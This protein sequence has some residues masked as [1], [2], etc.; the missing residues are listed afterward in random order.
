MTDPDLE[1]VVVIAPHHDDEVIGCGGTIVDLAGRGHPVDV[2][3]VTA[4]YCAQPGISDREVATAISE[5]EARKAGRL[6]GVRQQIFLREPDRAISYS[7]D[8]L[9]AMIRI[10]RKG[11]YAGVYFPHQDETD[12]E[13]RV[14][15]EVMNEAVWLAATAYLPELGEP[16]RLSRVQTYE[17]W[18]PFSSFHVQ[19]D[20]SPYIELKIE[21]LSAY[22]SK[23]SRTMAEQIVGLNHYRGAMAGR[24]ARAMEVFRIHAR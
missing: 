19:N 5:A 1:S 21:A 9:Y 17:V 16:V 11:V 4:G 12:R 14:V 13:H 23:L 7:Y 20:I 3:Y 22:V 8:L 10:L 24:P 15:Y 18:T 6:L 2:V